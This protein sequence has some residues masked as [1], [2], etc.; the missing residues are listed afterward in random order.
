MIP[1]IAP[2]RIPPLGVMPKWLWLEQV[3]NDRLE[4]L[5]A[6]IMRCLDKGVKIPLEWVEEYNELSKK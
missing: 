4:A 3:N 1:D 6:A 2:P 5:N